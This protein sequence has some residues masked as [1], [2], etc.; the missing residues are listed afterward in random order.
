M[1]NQNTYPLTSASLLSL[2]GNHISNKHL[3]VNLQ[4]GSVQIGGGKSS[5]PL[6]SVD[7]SNG[8]VA[9]FFHGFLLNSKQSSNCNIDIQPLEFWSSGIQICFDLTFYR[10]PTEIVRLKRDSIRVMRRCQQNY[11]STQMGIFRALIPT[12]FKLFFT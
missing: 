4:Q 5:L 11:D 8:I 9:C 10:C 3:C 2:E 12:K 7:G 6:V 1:K